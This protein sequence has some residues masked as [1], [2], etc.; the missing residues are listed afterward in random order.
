[1]VYEGIKIPKKILFCPIISCHPYR[2]LFVESRFPVYNHFTPNGVGD[3]YRFLSHRDDIIIGLPPLTPLT[4]SLPHFF[5]FFSFSRIIPPM[6]FGN[7]FLI[8]TFV[9]S[10]PLTWFSMKILRLMLPV[11]ILWG[12]TISCNNEIDLYPADAPK[13][14]YVLGCLDGTGGLQQVKIRKLI[15][16]NINADLMIND[17]AY[18]LPDTSVRVYLEEPSGNRIELHPVCYPPQS[19]GSFSQDSNFIYEIAGY[20]PGPGETCTL[21][22]EDPEIGKTLSAS[23]TAMM[24]AEFTYPVKESVVHGRFRFTD[25]NRPFHISFTPAPASVWTIS[26]KYVDFLLNGNLL[27]RKATYCGPSGYEAYNV[28]M[29]E[30]PLYYL[31]RIFNLTIPDDPNVDFRMFY[32]FDF[33]IWTADSAL[34]GFMGVANRFTDNRKQYFSNIDGG[35]GLFFATHH[36]RLKNVWPLEAFHQLLATNDTTR[37]LK[38]SGIPYDGPYTD[39]DSSLVNPFFSIKK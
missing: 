24:P 5:T 8:R 29:Q 22:I 31:W 10:P 6:S 25:A 39:P 36:D 14:L 17:P 16:G 37:H 3:G 28:S 38:F 9:L 27:C 12:L 32:R 11:A 4:P 7:P 21:K 2:V 20:R 15:T 35:M 18:Y 13:M 1:M 34:S 30:F 26:I 23:V 33:S 19:G